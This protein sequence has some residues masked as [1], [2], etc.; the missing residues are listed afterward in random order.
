MSTTGVFKKVPEYDG[1][2]DNWPLYSAKM[3]AFLTIHKLKKTI[4]ES[5]DQ[6]LPNNQDD[7]LDSSIPDEKKKIEAREKNEQAMTYLTISIISHD[8]IAVTKG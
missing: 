1:D 3:K 7:E 5:F 6:E 8:L 2:A 4:D